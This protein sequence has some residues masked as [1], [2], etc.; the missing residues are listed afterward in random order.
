MT[1]MRQLLRS[2]P[3]FD[4]VLPSFDT[5]QAPEQPEQL[6]AQWLLA[7]LDA[8]VLEPHA[9]TLST[10]DTDGR[11]DA[12]VLILKDVSADGWLFA[13]SAVSAKG[14]Q[15]TAHPQA[16]LTSYW[17]LQARQVRVRGEV[18]EAEPAASARDFLARSHQARAEALLGRQSRVRAEGQDEH[19][20]LED[21]EGL[22]R[23]TP[24]LVAPDWRLYV[25]RPQ[26]VEFWQG[27]VSRRHTRLR[28]RREQ[29]TWI[30]ELLWS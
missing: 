11:P 25:L 18:E 2:L 21:A 16:A 10:V 14:Q 13:S 3:V 1:E 6:Y 7:A 4:R 12:R 17:P 8:G 30:R 23:R 19:E 27:E 28:Y 5:A 20:Q 24:D 9:V 22:L 15:L 29:G 26:G